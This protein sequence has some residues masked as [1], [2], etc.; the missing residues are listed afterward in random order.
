MS[1]S[2]EFGTGSGQEPR[3]KTGRVR[4]DE[5]GKEHVAEYS[6]RS[7]YGNE[8]MY[9]VHCDDSPG[10]AD[11]YARSRVEPGKPRKSRGVTKSAKDLGL[12]LGRP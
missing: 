1:R 11:Y 8:H 10:L 2:E 7:Q 5:C 3:L 4:C 6:H 9:E 12:D